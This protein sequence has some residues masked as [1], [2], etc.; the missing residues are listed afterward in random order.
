[1][2]VCVCV[3]SENK[4]NKVGNDVCPLSKIPKVG[5]SSL[6]YFM[7]FVYKVKGSLTPKL[8]LIARQSDHTAS[9]LA[10]PCTKMAA[11]F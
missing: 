9:P 10:L 5:F 6:T 7:S 2:C 11:V 3:L 1:M 4:K 8:V